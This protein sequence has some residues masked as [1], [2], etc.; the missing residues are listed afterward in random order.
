MITVELTWPEILLATNAGVMRRVNAVRNRRQEPYGSRPEAAWNDDINGAIAELALAKHLNVFWAG[1]VGRIDLPDVGRLQ[2]RSKTQDGDRLVVIAS[3]DDT[4]I[5]VSV[6]VGLPVCRIDGWMMAKEAKRKEWLLPREG[7][8]DRYF[9]P[10]S[11][12]RSPRELPC[13][14]T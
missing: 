3:D 2:V 4:S 11:S 9:V 12:L 6:L 14:T 10:N 13:P 7:L 5:F 1:T 8:P